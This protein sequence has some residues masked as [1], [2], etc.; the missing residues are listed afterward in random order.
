MT[1]LKVMLPDAET[2]QRLEMDIVSAVYRKLAE[3]DYKPIGATGALEDGHYFA[4]EP[5]GQ[6]QVKT[7]GNVVMVKLTGVDVDRKDVFTGALAD[8]EQRNDGLTGEID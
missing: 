1:S 6:V 8:L 4:L 3:V 7:T 5:H 2:A